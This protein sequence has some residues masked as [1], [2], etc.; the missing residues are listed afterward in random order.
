MYHQE[1]YHAYVP[2]NFKIILNV[3][4][5]PQTHSDLYTALTSEASNDILEMMARTNHVHIL[6]VQQWLTATRPLVATC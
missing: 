3:L 6:T 4:L 2:N 5:F 1:W